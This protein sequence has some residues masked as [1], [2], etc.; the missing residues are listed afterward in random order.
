MSDYEIVKD[1]IR[2]VLENQYKN[3]GNA[4]EKGDIVEKVSE[5]QNLISNNETF[6]KIYGLRGNLT[7]NDYV[8]MVSEFE[9]MFN[10]KMDKGVI[11]QGDEQQARDTTWW[12]DKIKIK[13]QQEDKNYYATR[14]REFISRKLPL[15]VIK[16]LDDDTDSVMNNIGN[17]NDNRFEIFGMVVGH[18]QSGKTMNYSSLICKAADAGYKFIVVIAGDKNN[19]RNQ[20]QK[21]INEYFI[22]KDAVGNNVG[23]GISDKNDRAKNAYISHN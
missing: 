7:D 18:V 14:F 6:S 23:V 19:L 4:L 22:G 16:T 15:E 13:L 12:R 9:T 2:G 21:R 1:F 11:I 20:T 3:N 8:R 5:T 17:P 10:V